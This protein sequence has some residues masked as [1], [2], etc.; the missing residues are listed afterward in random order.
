MSPSTPKSPAQSMTVPQAK[1]TTEQVAMVQRR[2]KALEILGESLQIDP[3]MLLAILK[4]QIMPGASDDEIAAITI[5]ANVYDLNPILRE[6]YAFPDPKRKRI[7]PVVGVDGWA[8]II[9]RQTDYD[10]CEFKMEMTPEGKPISCTCKLYSK[11]RSHPLEI[12]EYFDEC[13]RNTDPWT[14]MPKRMLRHK[15]FIQAGRVAFGI[16]GIYDED[17]ARDIVVKDVTPTTAPAFLT[18]PEVIQPAAQE[19]QPATHEQTAAEIKQAEPTKEPE[20]AKAEEPKRDVTDG[21]EPADVLTLLTQLMKKDGVSEDQLTIHLRATKVAK[22]DQHWPELSDSKLRA[23]AN[24]WDRE[25][26]A[27]RAIQV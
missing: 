6:L 3:P 10:G 20:P 25:L 19:P 15:A 4:N 21:L 5:I 16:S 17:E 26:P 23:V 24:A 7:V 2:K 8:K 13:K 11:S 1:P 22:K 14:N 27:I 18:A 9:N 12:T